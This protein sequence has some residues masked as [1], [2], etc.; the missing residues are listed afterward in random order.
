LIVMIRLVN[1]EGLRG[2]LKTEIEYEAVPEDVKSKKFT[3]E[4]PFDKRGQLCPL[5]LWIELETTDFKVPVKR[6][7][8]RVHVG[9]DTEPAAFLVT[10]LR[11]GELRL[12]VQAFAMDRTAVASGLMRVQGLIHPEIKPEPRLLLTM[13]LGAFSIK[14]AEAPSR[15]EA[16]SADLAQFAAK[17]LRP[18]HLNSQIA[19]VSKAQLRTLHIGLLVGLMAAILIPFSCMVFHKPTSISEQL[20]AA[21]EL[22]NQ[23]RF[24]EA[25]RICEKVLFA[26]PGE[27]RV[28]NMLS[29]AQLQKARWLSLQEYLARTQQLKTQGRIKEA[30]QSLQEILSIDPA[31]EQALKLRSEIQSEKKDN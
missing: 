26:N 10:P 30:L 4:F 5:E 29:E 27:T 14:P 28:R 16:P 9:K 7:K 2:V 24:D 12:I 17:R 31:N 6:K 25:I 19:L 23:K 11:A 3:V 13:P 8:I 15:Q 1:S 18:A 21:Q 22:L 20:A